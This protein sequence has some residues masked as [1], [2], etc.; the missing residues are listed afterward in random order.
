[1][2]SSYQNYSANNDVSGERHNSSRERHNS[3]RERHNS[4]GERHNSSGERHN[5]SGERHNSSRERHN[6]EKNNS[7]F[8]TI[9]K[10]PSKS[11][12]LI[13]IGIITGILILILVLYFNFF[14]K[15]ST[16]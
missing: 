6:E 15:K 4:S 12:Y 2:Y 9:T 5:S 1:M 11:N 7:I 3:S 14:N 8:S 13:Y 16:P 10:A